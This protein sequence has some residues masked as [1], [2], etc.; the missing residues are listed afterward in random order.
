MT[1]KASH[2]YGIDL[3]RIICCFEVILIHF[4]Q[5]GGLFDS[6]IHSLMACATPTFFLLSFFLTA[7]HVVSSDDNE[8][9]R[10]I[11]RIRTPFHYWGFLSW[12]IWVVLLSGVIQKDNIIL[13]LFWQMVTGHVEGINPPLWFLFVL[14]NMTSLYRY[15]F[16]KCK[17][18][19]NWWGRRLFTR[20]DKLYYSVQ[21]NELSHVL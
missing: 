5:G 10:R 11:R 16:V 1:N 6:E 17:N 13:P 19:V 3:L 18:H 12:I 8:Y 20:C 15:I 21:W 4:W 14:G 7:K 2:N 9:Y